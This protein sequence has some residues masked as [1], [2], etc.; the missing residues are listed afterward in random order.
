VDVGVG[1]VDLGELVTSLG[2]RDGIFKEPVEAGFEGL[3]DMA[4]DDGA[5]DTEFP[6]EF[7][8]VTF[9]DVS[10]VFEV[11]DDVEVAFGIDY[12]FRV[13]GV[14]FE[15]GVFSVDEGVELGFVRD[16]D[17]FDGGMPDV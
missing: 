4:I 11:G 3:A 1:F 10:L 14:G 9:F 6:S 12:V 15:V 5:F 8:N 17:F 13:F 16:G 7:G 2:F